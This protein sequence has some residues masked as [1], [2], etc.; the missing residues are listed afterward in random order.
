MDYSKFVLLIVYRRAYTGICVFC[1]LSGRQNQV[2]R[3]DL[4]V[5]AEMDRACYWC[6]RRL[7]RCRI[8]N[9]VRVNFQSKHLSARPR[10]IEE[11]FCRGIFEVLSRVESW[12]SGEYA[13]SP[14]PPHQTGH[15]LFANTAFRSSSSRGIRSRLAFWYSIHWRFR[16]ILEFIALPQSPL[17]L[18]FRCTMKA[19]PLPSP[20]VMLSLR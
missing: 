15:S 19:L 13:L 9:F 8:S 16:N 1:P 18:S 10:K 5:T 14:A 6:N 4:C 12:R 11:H 20:K 17:L 7:W 2:N 3:C